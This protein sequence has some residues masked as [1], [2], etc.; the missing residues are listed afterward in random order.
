M[1]QAK[2]NREIT[3]ARMIEETKLM[4]APS[5]EGEAVLAAR[6]SSLEFKPTQRLSRSTLSYMRMEPQKCHE[7]A[8]AYTLL[9]PKKEARSIQGWWRIGDLLVFHSV[10]TS[11]GRVACITPHFTND[12]SILFAPD[13]D[14][15]AERMEGGVRHRFSDGSDIPVSVRLDRDKVAAY[16]ELILD[17]LRTMDDPYKA[18]DLAYE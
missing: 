6:L 18:V 14:I 17:R 11:D 1:G 8:H 7:N 9:D 3:R 4:T 12:E 16:A 15:V 2:K 13:P 5:Y 10:V